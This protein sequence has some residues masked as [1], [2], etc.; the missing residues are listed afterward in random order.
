MIP[1][2]ERHPTMSKYFVI[3]S[4]AVG[5]LFLSS[6]ASIFNRPNQPVQV[7]SQPAGLTFKVTDK[8]GAVMAAGTT[9]GEVNLATSSGYFSPAKYKFDFYKG[10]RHLGTVQLD[11]HLSGWYIGNAVVGGIIGLVV[12][13]PLTGSMYTLPNDVEFKG[14]NL[15]SVAH[16]HAGAV[17]IA[18]TEQLSSEQRA[19]LV[20][21]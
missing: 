18:S 4:A 1:A 19:R 15:A 9:P 12:I 2:L 16:S 5:S 8:D 6:C 13:D 20:R 3:A 17:T 11:A 7:V 21:L 10:K 14:S